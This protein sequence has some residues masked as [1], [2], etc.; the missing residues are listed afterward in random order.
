MGGESATGEDALTLQAVIRGDAGCIVCRRYVDAKGG[1]G[2]WQA[3][4]QQGGLELPGQKWQICPGADG[5][6]EGRCIGPFGAVMDSW[7]ACGPIE[8][9]MQHSVPGGWEKLECPDDHTTTRR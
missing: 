3:G 5:R 9:M 8:V 7:N 4:R 6:A 2:S 1:G